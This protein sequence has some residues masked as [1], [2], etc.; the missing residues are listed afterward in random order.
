M[1]DTLLMAVSMVLMLK[2][3]EKRLGVTLKVFPPPIFAGTTSVS[4]FCV[5]PLPP[6][7]NAEGG[8]FIYAFLGQAA[9]QETK[10]DNIGAL[11]LKRAWVARPGLG[12]MP[13]GLIWPSWPTSLTSCAPEGSCDK[14]LTPEKS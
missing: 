11:R 10:M 9:H 7:G 13:P 3:L 14:I 8:V 4:M 1:D 2:K 5:S 6:V 12:P